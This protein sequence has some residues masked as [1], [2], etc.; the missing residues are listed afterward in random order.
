LNVSKGDSKMKT[1]SRLLVFGLVTLAMA[2][3]SS[4]AS[5]QWCPPPP[6]CPPPPPNCAPLPQLGFSSYVSPGYGEV[7]THV[8]YGSQAQAIGLE[9]GDV[10]LSL[11]G[12]RLAYHGAWQNALRRAMANGGHVH[13][14]IR[15][16]RT[17]C[18]AH[19]TLDLAGSTVRVF[20]TT[21]RP[22]LR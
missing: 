3:A 6:A 18:T 5:A 21:H 17:G 2:V 20:A 8:R 4:R 19:R 9:R 15:E 13:L 10:I 1:R 12:Y 22:P 11:N 7:V 14:A 16:A